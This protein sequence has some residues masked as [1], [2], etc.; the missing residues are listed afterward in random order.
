MK[1]AADLV[2]ETYRKWYEDADRRLAIGY[3]EFDEG[4]LFEAFVKMLKEDREGR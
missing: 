3:L 4:E 2:A 1:D